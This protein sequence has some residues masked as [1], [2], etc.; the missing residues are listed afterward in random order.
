MRNVILLI[1]AMLFVEAAA[2]QITITGDDM[3]QP[4]VTYPLVNAAILDLSL[5]EISGKFESVTAEI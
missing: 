1:P 4:D 2:S 3:P 5:G